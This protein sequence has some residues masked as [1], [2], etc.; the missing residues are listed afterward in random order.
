[1]LSP[2]YSYDKAPINSI[3]WQGADAAAVPHDSFNRKAAWR[4]NLCRCFWNS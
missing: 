1:M 4:F 3:F 2:G